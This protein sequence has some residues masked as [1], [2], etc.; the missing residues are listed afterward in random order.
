MVNSEIQGLDKTVKYLKKIFGQI[1]LTNTNELN[2]ELYFLKMIIHY[3]Y[4][5]QKLLVNQKY[6]PLLILLKCPL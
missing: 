2:N 1:K 5:K 3:K 4:L 6:Y